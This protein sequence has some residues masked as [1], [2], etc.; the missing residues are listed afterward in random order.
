MNDMIGE[1]TKE[2]V[3]KKMKSKTKPLPTEF[4]H[5]APKDAVKVIVEEFKLDLEKVYPDKKIVINE[6]N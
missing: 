1:L 2:E 3:A 6:E 4:T 5:H